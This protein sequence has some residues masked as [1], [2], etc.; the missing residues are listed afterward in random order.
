MTEE[1]TSQTLVPTSGVSFDNQVRIVRAYVVL[2]DNGT[3]PVHYKEVMRIT[4]LGR[5]QISGVNSFLVMLG[6]LEK[7]SRGY[8]KPTAAAVSF[9]DCNP[10]AEDFEGLSPTLG[11]SMLF[12]HVEQYLKVHGGGSSTSLAEY[13][14][15]RAETDQIFRVQSAL[16]WLIRSGIIERNDRNQ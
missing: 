11:N 12:T 5:T 4:R 6:L 14:M 7:T 15:E 13:I 8:Y 10:G 3:N 2:S 16:E 9:C 1:E